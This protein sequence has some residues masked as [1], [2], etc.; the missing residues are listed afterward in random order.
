MI[1]NR[2]GEGHVKPLGTFDNLIAPVSVDLA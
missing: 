2:P 1:R